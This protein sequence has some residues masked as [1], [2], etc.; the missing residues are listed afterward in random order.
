MKSLR[1]FTVVLTMSG[2]S[3]PLAHATAATKNVTSLQT[4]TAATVVPQS[5]DEIARLSAQ[6]RR[7]GK[8]LGRATFV[9]SFQHLNSA[10]KA[11]LEAYQKRSPKEGGEA[12]HRL[13]LFNSTFEPL[14]TLATPQKPTPATCERVKQKIK[15][16]DLSGEGNKSV[17]SADANEALEWATLF[18][19]D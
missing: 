15:F 18:C 19:K 2:L 4:K 1:N 6:L 11:S 8:T 9:Q 3:L 7:E 5:R 17:L 16:E 13:S 10:M 12:E 14:N